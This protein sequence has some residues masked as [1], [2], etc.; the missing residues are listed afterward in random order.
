MR[1]YKNLINDLRNRE[2]IFQSTDISVLEE[3][4]KKY[5]INLYC[6]FDPTADSLHVGH[7]VILFC[8]KRFKDY[9]HK[10]IILIGGATSLVGDPSFK[11]IK[12][13]VNQEEKIFLFSEKISRQITNLFEND[14]KHKR[15]KILNNFDWLSKI[16][17]LELLKKFGKYFSV[18]KMINKEFI[19]N[20]IYKTDNSWISFSEFSYNILQ[21]YDFAY[22]FKKYNVEMQIGGSDQWGNITSGIDLIR[23]KYKKKVLGFTTPLLLNNNGEKF[24]KTGTETIWLDPKKT[25]PYKF[26][27]FWINIKDEEIKLFLMFFT[28]LSIEEIKD[29]QIEKNNSKKKM[30]IKKFL[31][32]FITN[33]VHGKKRLESAIRI[34]DSL[35]LNN[36]STL[37][38]ED[39]FQLEKDGIPSI[40]SKIGISLCE[41]LLKSKLVK[42]KTQAKNIIRSKAITI[43]GK[44]CLDQN[45]IFSKKD[46]LFSKYSLVKFGKKI[47]FLIIW[48]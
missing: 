26:Y 4:V 30:E 32:N 36:F 10:P 13:T 1:E 3:K 5:K 12:R 9:G 25:S 20:R 47:H 8:L 15:L 46:I 39:F 14:P 33:F 45:Y 7:L 2:L 43:N 16:S 34:T 23:Y 35:F 37:N 21:S 18:N 24:G 41:C 48:I 27:Q 31:A 40:I 28:S 42:S 29:I 22:L 17:I 19:K 6:G 44:K 38:K 11:K